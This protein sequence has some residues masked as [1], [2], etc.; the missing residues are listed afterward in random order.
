MF[1]SLFAVYYLNLPKFAPR[2]NRWVWVLTLVVVVVI[3]I[4][5][6]L[7]YPG[8]VYI[9]E[10]A[11]IIIL[12]YFLTLFSAG[13][14]VWYKG[15]NNARFYVLGWFF[16]IA[17]VFIHLFAL[18]DVLPN[19]H[20]LHNS[21]Y[22]GV[23]LEA[24]LFALALG[25]RLNSLKKE[26]DMV[27]AENLQII[28]KQ[29]DMLAQKVEEKTKALQV[30]YKEVQTN[31]EELKVTQ[32]VVASHN[33][34]LEVQ[35]YELSL[36]RNR[37]GQSFRAAQMIQTALLP[38]VMRMQN[39]FAEYFILN[40]P[41]DVV[42]GDF[43]W[44][45]AYHD[46]TVLVVADCTGHG[47]PGAFMTFIGSNLLDK[48]VRLKKIINP[49]EILNFMNTEVIQVLNQK[50][51]KRYDGG[52]DAA[53][54]MLK[55][56]TESGG[57]TQVIFA[58]AKRDFWWIKPHSQELDE[59]RGTRRSIGGFQPKDNKPYQKHVFSL[60]SG[61]QFYVGSDGLIDQNDEQRCKFGS[62]RL[63]EVLQKSARLP[64]NAQKTELANVLKKH[65]A[66]AEQRDDIL[67]LGVKV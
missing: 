8:L 42:S 56:D 34:L 22:I 62:V 16:T 57:D 27:R 29:N 48:I 1:I 10:P 61:S 54:I 24:L 11:Q 20:L 3:P 6:I 51:T 46:T 21:P 64:L 59:I 26:K 50:E 14:Y 65:M 25:D 53:V 17:S 12:F 66:N 40:M 41:K 9:I 47:V 13:V 60:P 39:A 15:N 43:Y 30:A 45:Y 37:I 49:G 55:K 38:T 2:L 19:H 44:L 36:Y 18:Q 33:Q 5:S 52:M 63:K 7:D 35:N 58:G 28:E 31:N 32:E 67:W 4:L 23:S